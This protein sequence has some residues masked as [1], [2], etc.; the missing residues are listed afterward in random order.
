M[1]NTSNSFFFCFVIFFQINVTLS[2]RFLVSYSLRLRFYDGLHSLILR[3]WNPGLFLKMANAALSLAGQVSVAGS[4]IAALHKELSSPSAP[5]KVI[6]PVKSPSPS[7]RVAF[8]EARETTERPPTLFRDVRY[9]RQFEGGA[10]AVSE[11]EFEDWE[12]QVGSFLP[13]SLHL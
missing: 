1:S 13:S 8:V 4:A 12:L 6:K 2:S 5:R 10:Y 11:E 9:E 7:R 3:V